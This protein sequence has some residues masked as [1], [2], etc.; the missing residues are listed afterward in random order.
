MSSSI[1]NYQ[2]CWD[3]SGLKHDD[4]NGSPYLQAFA[5]EIL[6]NEAKQERP[7]KTN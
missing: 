2:I 5:Q 6:D 1:H 3:R 7:L 4:D